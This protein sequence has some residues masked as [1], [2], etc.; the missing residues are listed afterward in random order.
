MADGGSAARPAVFLDRDGTVV[1]ERDYLR[2][3]ADVRLVPGA[4]EAIRSLHDAGFAVV[5]VTN[6]SGIARGLYTEADYR[7]VRARLASLLAERDATPDGT[8]HCPHHPDF[9]GPCDCRKPDTGMHRTAAEE[10]GL[11]LE[12][13]FC[14]GDKTSDVLAAQALGGTGILVR[15]GYGAEQEG[16]PD[17]V[18]V[19]DD[20]L[21]AARR[22][23]SE[24]GESVDPEGRPG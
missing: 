13:C 1:V 22:I 6:Q 16:L 23:L 20:V 2:D 14:V 11:R 19:V 5:I 24:T 18:V 4:D 10:L 15:T 3:P 17:G 9:T 21:Q 8:Y 7:A 12:G